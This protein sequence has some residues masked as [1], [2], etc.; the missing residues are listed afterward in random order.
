MH[1]VRLAVVS[2]VALAGVMTTTPALAAEPVASAS[3]AE[4]AAKR[5]PKTKAEKLKRM[6]QLTKADYTS[7]LGWVK[8]QKKPKPGYGFDWSTDGCSHAPDNPTGISFYW[9]CYRHD[10]G[11]RNYKKLV[12]KAKFKKSYKARVDS[13]FYSDMKS[14]CWG[15]AMPGRPRVHCLRAAK[16]YYDT[17]VRLGA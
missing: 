11:Y 8:E 2:G 17:V 5:K 1:K 7:Y 15:F 3:V 10:F 4:A 13:A 6:G 16:L 12:G 14:R 9:P